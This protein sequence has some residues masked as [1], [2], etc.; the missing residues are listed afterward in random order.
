[1]TPDLFGI[2]IRVL[3]AAGIVLALIVLVVWIRARRSAGSGSPA[4]T[5]PDD[6]L[7][8]LVTQVKY[9]LPSAPPLS[10]KTPRAVP[11]AALEHEQEPPDIDL[12]RDRKD[13]TES[14]AALSEKY[15]VLE[16][17]L[18]TDDGLVVATSA[19]HDVQNDAV[20]YSQV[21]HNHALPEEP[22]VTIFELI[23]RESHLIGIIRAGAARDISPDRKQQ[24]REDTKVILQW[25]L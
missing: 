20:T 21:A 7:A 9:P 19:D 3:L 23:H 4:A 22:G 17:T 5:G 15:S 12:T 1:M 2:D 24:I 10:D 14:L 18:A 8:G 16:I 13:I 11:G 25:W 6:D